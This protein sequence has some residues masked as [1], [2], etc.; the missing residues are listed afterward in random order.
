M[1][2]IV[3]NQPWGVVDIVL[4]EGRIF[5]QQNWYYIWQVHPPMAPWTQD[6]KRNLHNTMD[7]QIWSVWSN[8]RVRIP[9]RLGPSPSPQ[10]RELFQRTGGNVPI[11]FDIRWVTQP[12]HWEVTAVKTRPGDSSR[13][14]VEFD[15]RKITI[16]SHDVPPSGACTDSG[17][18]QNNFLVAPHE[19]G[20]TIN[21]DDEYTTTSPHLADTS[22]IM[23][24]GRQVRPR[25]LQLIVDT[26]NKMVRGAN[27]ILPAAI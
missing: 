27:F 15:T 25:H 6:E 13:S 22:S 5:F 7:R 19:F 3:S 1:P 26:L 16:Y 4:H 9:M 20:H 23:N 12:G 14:F 11:N 10:A 21:A 18:C 17:V 2:H 24:I 8:H